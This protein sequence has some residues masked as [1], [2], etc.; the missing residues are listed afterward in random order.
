MGRIAPLLILGLACAL[1]GWGT[2]HIAA[3]LE[4]LRQERHAERMSESPEAESAAPALSR[5]WILFFTAVAT[6]LTAAASDSAAAYS[7]A[8]L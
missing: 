7:N 8:E 1:F 5:P 2:V 3:R 4:R 6:A